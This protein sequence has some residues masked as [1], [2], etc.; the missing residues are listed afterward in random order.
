[1]KR[2]A[3]VLPDAGEGRPATRARSF[4]LNDPAPAHVQ[5]S[6]ELA[7][8]NDEEPRPELSICDLP[9]EILG[10]VFKSIAP[11]PDSSKEVAGLLKLQLVSR[12]FKQ[13]FELA[14]GARVGGLITA[15]PSGGLLRCTRES[16]EFYAYPDVSGLCSEHLGLFRP[17]PWPAILEAAEQ[18]A[19]SRALQE[20]HVRQIR[21]VL[22]SLGEGSPLDL[23]RFLSTEMPRDAGGRRLGLL[24]AHA[25][26]LY[27]VANENCTQRHEDWLWAHVLMGWVVDP[28]NLSRT[29]CGGA[30]CYF[31]FEH[32]LR[33]VIGAVQPPWYTYDWRS[34][35]RHHGHYS[36]H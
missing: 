9:L 20:V 1:M 34:W 30:T 35:I 24:A 25:A 2:A 5:A 33:R 12:K 13:A 19:S 8:V 27:R 17:D 7:S 28:W 26:S 16:C 32:H 14:G 18:S 15:L 11:K 3:P 36:G 10:L 23:A 31:T 6:N 21:R 29:P 4:P 22:E